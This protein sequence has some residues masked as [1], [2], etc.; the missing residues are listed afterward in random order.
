LQLVSCLKLLER[1]V[2]H[3]QIRRRNLGNRLPRAR[4]KFHRSYN[5]KASNRRA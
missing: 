1:L 2:S 3:C 5:R 4:E